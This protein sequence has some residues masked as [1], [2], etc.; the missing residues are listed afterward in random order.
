MAVISGTSFIISGNAASV[1]MTANPLTDSTIRSSA[2]PPPS[3]SK[4]APTVNPIG[5]IVQMYNIGK[6]IDIQIWS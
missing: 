4:A 2:V 1:V 6:E 3:E 5:T